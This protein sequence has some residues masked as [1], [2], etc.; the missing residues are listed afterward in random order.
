M[1]DQ[2]THGTV[3]G[4]IA[5]DPV[6]VRVICNGCGEE[7]IGGGAIIDHLDAHN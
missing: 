1:S 3:W 5:K 6:N 4:A 7:F 2:M